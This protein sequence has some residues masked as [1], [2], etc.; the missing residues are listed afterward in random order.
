M[1]EQVS[2]TRLDQATADDFTIMHKHMSAEH[3]WSCR[4]GAGVARG[5]GRPMPRSQGRSP[6]A[7]ATD[8]NA[9]PS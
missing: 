8:G 9:G 1:N 3:C 7:L 5:F 6:R 2:F 4:P